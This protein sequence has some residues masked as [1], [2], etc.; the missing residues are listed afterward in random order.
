MLHITVMTWC[1]VSSDQYNYDFHSNSFSKSVKQEFVQFVRSSLIHLKVDQL[2]ENMMLMDKVLGDPLFIF[3]GVL[4]PMG[5]NP[6]KPVALS[7]ILE[8]GKPEGMG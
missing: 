2:P 7:D 8:L 1:I 6:P 3:Q 4:Q 5:Y